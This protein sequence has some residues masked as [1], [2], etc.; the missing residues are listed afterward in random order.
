[1]LKIRL[2]RGGSKR[3][4]YYHVV[5]A[6]ARCPRDGRFLEKLGSYNPLLESANE[7][8]LV[9]N[10]ERIQHWLSVGAQPTDRIEKFLVDA[11]LLKASPRPEQTK[12][13]LPKAKAQEKMKADAE[14]KAAAEEALRAAK[15]A[16]E[17]AAAAPAA[18]PAPA[19]EASA[20][21]AEEVPTEDAAPTAE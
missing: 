3:R 12:K 15:V 17:E 8:R 4:P 1:M 10:K 16:A 5:V 21:T 6:D 9:L 13:N 14:K 20:P 7:N 11:G 19:E 18:E 2:T